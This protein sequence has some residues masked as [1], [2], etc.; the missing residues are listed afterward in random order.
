MALGLLMLLQ[1]SLLPEKDSTGR[2]LKRAH[3]LMN[4]LMH[5]AIASTRE[6]LK[7]R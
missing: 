2:A 5:V 7:N 6:D 1:M 4:S 3:A